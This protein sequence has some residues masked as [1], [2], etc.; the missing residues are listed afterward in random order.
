MKLSTLLSLLWVAP[1]KSIVAAIDAAPSPISAKIW[2]AFDA[3]PS[4][5]LS[6]SKS[7]K[8]PAPSPIWANTDECNDLGEVAAQMIAYDY[9][10]FSM[11][12]TYG[13]HEHN[14]MK[15]CRSVAYGICKGAVYDNGCDGISTSELLDLQN[16]CES[17]VNSMTGGAEE[18]AETEPQDLTDQVSVK[19]SKTN[20][21]CDGDFNSGV[22][23]GADV[24][25]KMWKEQ[26]SSCS[27]IWGFEDQVD[28][29]LE[30]KYPTD[31]S[32]WR[33]NSCHEGMKKGADQV[34]AKYEKQCLDDTPDECYDLGQA[35]AQMIAFDFCPFSAQSDATAYGQP[36]YKASCRSVAY[37]V[38]E[39]AIYNNVRDNG[40]SISTSQLNNLQNKCKGQVDSMTGGDSIVQV[41][42]HLRK[43]AM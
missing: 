22:Y 9:C 42:R 29:Y 21:S 35:A 36:N 19:K 32:D 11:T 28:N 12:S 24:A 16:Q 40:C 17:Q 38:C 20:M 3:A 26:G 2:A 33:K 7:A 18:E 15:E 25:E 10:P 13:H 37:G 34:V 5:S 27:N 39:G 30:S 31:T 4:P 43:G 6:L 23:L 14:Y 8:T 41:S 1:N